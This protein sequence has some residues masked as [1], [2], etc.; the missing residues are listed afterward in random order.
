MICEVCDDI[1]RTAKDSHEKACLQAGARTDQF[2]RIAANHF[3]FVR[4]Y[5]DCYSKQYTRF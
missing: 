3:D 4:E 5:L 1:R 2:C